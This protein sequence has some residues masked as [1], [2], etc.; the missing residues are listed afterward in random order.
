M[1]RTPLR[2]AGQAWITPG[3]LLGLL[4]AL[5]G[6]VVMH[7][8]SD[9][10]AAGHLEGAGVH[11]TSG[12]HSGMSEVGADAMPDVVRALATV[13][14]SVAGA[15]GSG[16]SDGHE[17]AMA[18]LCLAVLFAGL[19]MAGTF[20]HATAYCVPRIAEVRLSGVAPRARAPD[21]PDLHRLSV[22]RC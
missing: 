12:G 4:V 2:R 16:G 21:P 6:L 11:A 22:H 14:V 10:G 15:D 8:L 20:R 5:S 17:L 3:R 7:G 19:L 13:S 9:H 1:Q 18:G